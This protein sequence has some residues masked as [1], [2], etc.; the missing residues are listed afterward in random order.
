MNRPAIFLLA[1]AIVAADQWAKQIV[2]HG[3][4]VGESRTVIHGLLD[5]TFVRN[6]GG[7][8]GILPQGT[9]ALSV[10]AV[11]AA[12]AIVYYLARSKPPYPARLAL[13][14]ALPLGGSLGNLI[15]RVRLRYVVDY[16]DVYVGS[17]H[18]PVFNIADAAICTGVALLAW[19]FWTMPSAAPDQ[20]ATVKEK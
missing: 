19:R 18:W 7:A 2:L 14:L 12:A 10:A 16:L 20:P 5:L 1:A 13:G 4:S 6:T 17:H 15:D 11:A 9:Q 8:F 3:F